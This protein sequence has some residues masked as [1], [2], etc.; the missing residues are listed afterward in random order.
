MPRFIFHICTHIYFLFKEKKYFS[1][2]KKVRK[3]Y[4]VIE[5]SLSMEDYYYYTFIDRC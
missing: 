4:D 5:L 3:I 1:C 2:G